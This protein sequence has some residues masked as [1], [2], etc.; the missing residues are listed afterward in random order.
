MIEKCDPGIFENEGCLSFP[1]LL[2]S[3]IRHTDIDA[4]FEN[5]KGDEIFVEFSGLASRCFQHELD[6]C[7]GVLI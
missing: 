4:H 2:V 1:N 7:N 6:H 3:V 5:E